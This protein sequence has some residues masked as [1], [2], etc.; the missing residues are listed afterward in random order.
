M[1][2]IEKFAAPI[3]NRNIVQPVSEHK[4]AE[5]E[6]VDFQNTARVKQALGE[7]EL[8]KQHNGDV[9]NQR[10]PAIFMNLLSD[11][12]VTAGYMRNIFM[13]M[14]IVALIPM[15]NGSL[16]EEMQQLFSELNL[17]P[18]EI[19]DEMINQENSSSAF[20]GEFFDFLRDVLAENKSPEFKKAVISVLKAVNS[21]KSRTDIMKALSASFGFLS[22]QMKPNR[23][24][25][26]ALLNISERF[27]DEDSEEVFQELKS[28]ALSVLTDVERSVLFN[29]QTERLISMIRYNISRYNNDPDF[30]TSSVNYLMTMLKEGDKSEFLQLLYDHLSY[31][32][33]RSHE[34]ELSDSK[35]MNIITDI[36]RLQSESEEIKALD[37][38]SVETIIHSMLSSPSNFTPLL[39]FIIPVEY[40]D[41]ASFAEIWID[42]DEESSSSEQGPLRQIH[43]LIVFDM[44]NLGKMETELFV[45]DNSIDLV[46]YCSDD[47]QDYVESISKD[48]RKCADFS[49]YRINSVN[50]RTLKQPRS[51]VD[52]FD[53]LSVRRSGINVKI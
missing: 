11:P 39:H 15:Q 14:D 46:L 47:V 19:A 38:E 28:D 52:V 18:E 34:D 7:S 3:T 13:M 21:E 10:G 40:E 43:M 36:L 45:R 50:I 49:D 27:R 37:S 16:T 51:L 17:F 26:A 29:S 41:V 20:K 24:I 22:A 2:N 35:V 8:L 1:A 48:L 33:N 9:H 53:G 4:S 12:Q 23:E 42:P 5:A 32:E 30:L 25:S 44:D 31:F 6:R